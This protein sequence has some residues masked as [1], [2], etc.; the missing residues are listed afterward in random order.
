MGE[1]AAAGLERS[2]DRDWQAREHLERAAVSLIEAV[3]LDAGHSVSWQT[4]E[5]VYGLLTPASPG[6]LD[7]GGR[8][9]LNMDHPL[10]PQ[11]FRQAG[12]QLVR[13]LAAAG[14]RDDA[15]VWRARMVGEF[16]LPPDLFAPV[17][18]GQPAPR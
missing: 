7:A 6:V 9:A 14:M 13:Q 3:L 1:A 11:H 2:R 5:R 12:A 16:G 4:L 17:R 15:E 18:P 10:V 8:P